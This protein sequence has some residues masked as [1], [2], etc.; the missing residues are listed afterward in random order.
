MSHMGATNDAAP[1]L[2]IRTV[3][4]DNVVVEKWREAIYKDAEGAE[5]LELNF[6]LNSYFQY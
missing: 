6:E 5:E 4:L 2:N 3:D 1:S